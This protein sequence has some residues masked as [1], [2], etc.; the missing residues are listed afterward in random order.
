MSDL[1]HPTIT[2][3]AFASGWAL[4]VLFALGSTSKTAAFINRNK[5]QIAADFTEWLEIK[6]EESTPPG[7]L[8]R[9]A[10]G[11]DGDCIDPRCPQL[12]DNE[13]HASGRDC[14]LEDW[15]DEDRRW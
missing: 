14:P 1:S 12:R 13:P 6:V 11:K 9:C 3:D 5:P 7:A 15:D 8:K 10:A 4:G 2:E